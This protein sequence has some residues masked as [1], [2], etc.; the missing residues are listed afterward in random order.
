MRIRG[1]DHP[2]TVASMMIAFALTLAAGSWILAGFLVAGVFVVAYS[3]YTRTG[4]GINQHPYADL[5]I[6]GGKD[7]P[8]N[9]RPPQPV[10]T[11]AAPETSDNRPASQ[12]MKLS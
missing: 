8:Q 5:D 9:P 12:G 3:Y 11:R 1:V 7:L 4:S 10:G 6:Q 2:R